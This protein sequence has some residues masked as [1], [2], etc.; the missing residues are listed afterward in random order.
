MSKIKSSTIDAVRDLSISEVLEKSGT[1]LKKVGREYLTKCPWHNDTNPSLTVNDDKN[2]CFCFVCGGGSDAIAYTQQKL[3]LDFAEAVE[4]IAELFNIAVEHENEDPQAV[5][6]LRARRMQQME[7]LQSEQE[8]YRAALKKPE[9]FQVRELLVNRGIAPATAKYFGLGYA[10]HGFFANRITVPIHN[11]KGELVGFS[12]R[13]VDADQLPKYKNS[14]A[15]ELF[16][17]NKIVFNEHRAQQSI[18]ESETIIFVE[19]HFD[20]IS[21]FQHGITN[22]VALQGTA[23]PDPSVTA[24][25]AKRATRFVLCYDGDEGG[26]KATRQFIDSVSSLAYSGKINL[27]VAQLPEGMDPD[28]CLRSAEVDL[29]ELIDNSKPWIDYVIDELL[30]GADLK[31]VS[32]YSKVENAIRAMIEKI[33]SPALRQFYIDKASQLLVPGE[34]TAS[35]LASQWASSLPRVSRSATWQKPGEGYTRAIVEKRLLRL[36]LHAPDLKEYCKPLFPHIKLPVMCWL[37]DRILELEENGLE[38][39]PCSLMA[40]LCVAEPHY[41]TAV[42]PIVKPTIKIERSS[43]VVRH[44]EDWLNRPTVEES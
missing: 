34:K 3:S 18:L 20:V 16:D 26:K 35:R 37:R 13:A 1:R 43:G 31:D 42:R 24:R 25:L 44:I 15:S 4:R 21:M 19:G 12:G 17:K 5:A 33:N 11:H 8:G 14:S 10:Q 9:A 30:T 29:V 40:L 32:V 2:L 39:T 41:A 7:Q 6:R 38:A 22:V 27:S 28:E 23:A 36:Y